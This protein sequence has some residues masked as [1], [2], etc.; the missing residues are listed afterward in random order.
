MVRRIWHANG[1]EPHL[2]KTFKVSNDVRFAEKPDVIVGS[3]STRQSAPWFYAPMRR[4][5][6][7]RW[8]GRSEDRA[9]PPRFRSS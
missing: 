8:I 1:L 7:R 5:R 3:I 6:S 9:R 4:V 2:V